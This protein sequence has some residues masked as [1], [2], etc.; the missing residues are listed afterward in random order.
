MNY[1]GNLLKHFDLSRFP[2]F[3][4]LEFFC[5]FLVYFSFLKRIFFL[6]WLKIH[7]FKILFGSH[8]EGKLRSMKFLAFMI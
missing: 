7:D 3:I 4:I 8:E 1:N 5:S 6:L 2:N